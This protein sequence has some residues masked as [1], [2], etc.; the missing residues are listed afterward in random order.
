MHLVSNAQKRDPMD[1]ILAQWCSTPSEY[2]NHLEKL[3][4]GNNNQSR[5]NLWGG[6]WTHCFLKFLDDPSAQCSEHSLLS[7]EIGFVFVFFFLF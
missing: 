4:N 6:A 3:N 1:H 5:P 7:A 2:E